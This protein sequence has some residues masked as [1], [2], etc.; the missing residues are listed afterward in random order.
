MA[1]RK[2]IWRKWSWIG[3]VLLLPILGLG[4]PFASSPRPA[5]AGTCP[6]PPEMGGPSGVTLDE[7]V[8]TTHFVVYYTTD[9][10]DGTHRILSEAQAQQV[11]D[12]LEF[13]WDR[14]VNDPDFGL[15]SPL[16]LGGGSQ[17]EVWIYDMPRGLGSTWHGY[18]HMNIDSSYVRDSTTNEDSRLQAE[19]TPLHELFHRSQFR[20][21]GFEY[22]DDTDL[23]VVEGQA[24]FME[25]EVFAD[26]DAGNNTQYILRANAYLGNA[27]WDVT[28]A[29]YNACIFWKYFAER[30]GTA[31]DEPERGV[32]TMRHFWEA[33]ETVGAVNLTTIDQALD[34]LGYPAV[35]FQDVFHD[36]I[37]A[38]YTKDLGTVPDAK[39]SYIDDDGNPY[40]SVPKTVDVS[41]SPGS[42]STSA[43]QSV[44]RYAAKYYRI[45]PTTSCPALGFDFHRDAGTPV[46]HIVTIKDDA[47]VDHWTSTTAD[48]SKTV[49]N[50]DYDEMIAVVGGY[51][52]STQVD[53]S[54]GCVDLAIDIK[55]PTT[56]EP[57]FVGSILNPEKFLVRLAVTST[58]GIKVEGLEAQDFD[59][60][61]GTQAAD[62]I[63][64]AYVQSQ[65]WLLVRAPTQSTAGDYDLTATFGA[66]TDTETTAVRYITR[67]HDDMLIVDRSGSMN[68]SDK[69]GAAKSAA[70]LYVDATADNNM[71][72]L[73]SFSGD[74][75]EPNEDATLDYDLATVN[76]TVRYDLKT[77]IDAL[78][79][80][81]MTSIGDGLHL[82]LQ[83]LD[84][85]S[86][87]DHPCAMVL[88]SDGEENEAR[89]WSDIQATVI[90]SRCVVDTIALGPETDMVLLQ[91]IASLTGGDYYY[92]PEENKRIEGV[93]QVPPD[94]RQELAG[95]YEFVEAD[96]AGRER[97]FEFNGTMEFGQRYSHTITIGD[98]VPEVV[99][100]ANYPGD[101]QYIM[102][103]LY[104]PDGIQ[105]DCEGPGEWCAGDSTHQLFRISHPALKPGDWTLV[106]IPLALEGEEPPAIAQGIPYLA[107]ASGD[108]N[109]T[110]HA[111]LGAPLFDRFQGVRMPIL[112]ALSN[113]GPI[114][115]AFISAT[116][117]MPNGLSQ[118]LTLVDDGEHGDGGPG[119]GVYGNLFNLGHYL[120]PMDPD[121][122]QGSYRIQIESEGIP[123]TIGPRFE[124]LS[125]AIEKDADTDGDGMPDNWEDANGLDKL[126]DDAGM[127]PDLDELDNLGEYNA[128][129]YPHNSDSDG[130]GENDGSEVDLFGQDP[131]DPADDEI[132][133][134]D[135]VNVAP[136]VASNVLTF[137]VDPDYDRLR[138][139]RSTSPDSGFVPVENDVAP[140]GAYTDTG[141][142][143]DTTYYYHMMA[144]DGDG[145]R[146]AVS[147]LLSATP[148]EDPF[149]PQ[150]LIVL[151][152]N[153]ADE[154]YSREV[155]LYFDFEEPADEMDVAEV[156]I[157][158]APT[159][160][161][162]S[163][164][165]Y[166]T[167]LPWTLSGTLSA[168][169][170]AE[171]YVRYRDAAQNESRDVAGDS[172]LFVEY[173]YSIYLPLVIRS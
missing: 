25:D 92:V 23:F 77:A 115:G 7:C 83:R 124:H 50:D 142:T 47:L 100:F 20:Y 8:T 44:E 129:T 119:D 131:L 22:A 114:T 84:A 95:T 111:F 27:N 31:T 128:G 162:T 118:V 163:W 16:V 41:V 147:P 117:F 5:W 30:Y 106:V 154:T 46:Y 159:F 17:I 2:A 6:Q 157:S 146:S 32:D 67:L 155:L 109:L 167:T 11:A 94:W 82:G 68:T 88:L 55:D 53:V 125:F 120:D 135:W 93:E 70:R 132:P 28:T 153:G 69:I 102:A 54:Y 12:N 33:C 105:I 39:Y 110:M 166:S 65:Y 40:A 51:G 80:D 19:A 4:L 75:T 10:A 160:S 18:N 78:V 87:P 21:T 133:A 52:T 158:N 42:Y 37:L 85:L 45:R 24:K 171:V 130:G 56:T 63:L 161:D 156:M 134:I 121:G 164:Q 170:M 150:N 26:L 76:S 49:V 97:L 103:S 64:G 9:T 113:D 116:V 149:P 101:Y 91:E 141:L 58:Q 112:A 145:H 169:D 62:V 57:A 71:L 72:G 60:T 126:T 34:N 89:F 73:V 36:W 14:Y 61:V 139:F 59:V 173:E 104:D 172:I 98:D 140:T 136:N 38:N 81:G 74:L 43:N 152:N 90:A 66:A 165:P 148:K 29:S 79:A 107:G 3:I 123:D 1:H 35:T 151:I 86:D 99:F 143:N 15:R 48:W 144:V 138:L 122:L 96:L 13:A 168:G 127:D 108:T 137:A